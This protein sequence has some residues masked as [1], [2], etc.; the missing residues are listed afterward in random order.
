MV[1]LPS[2]TITLLF[3]DIEGSTRLLQELGDAYT[4]VLEE[5]H[6]R[7]REAFDAHAGAVVD[8]QGDGFFVA[9][10]RADEAVAAAAD[11]QRALA[12]LDGVRVRMGIH[13]GHPRRGGAGYVGLDVHRAA[14]ICAAAHGGQVLLSQTTHEL[15]PDA[16]A[17]DL[18][19]HRLRDLTN[20]QRLYQLQGEGLEASFAPLRTL[21]NRPT[22]L[23]VQ[24]TP[25]IGR[26]G[27]LAAITELMRR[28]D[29]RLVTLH[30]PGGCGKTRLALQA[31]AE[32]ID[33]FPEGVFFV[34]LEAV[35]DPGLVIPT[36]AQTLGVNDA[37]ASSL[38]EALAGFLADRRLLLVLDNFEHLLEAAPRLT[39]LLAR[40][41]VCMLV[42]SRAALR[43]TG[44][45]ELEVPPLPVPDARHADD[46]DAL[47]Q[48]E[49]SGA[50][51]RAR[52]GGQ[53]GLRRRRGERPSARRDLH[54][55]RR[56]AAR[57]RARG[58]PR[59]SCS[60]PR[61]C[62]PGSRTV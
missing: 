20:P 29:V 51:H 13:T 41:T 59:A 39:E 54:P 58:R 38:D 44:E 43:L 53:R 31:G 61:Q 5:H 19:E 12:G 30:G 11:A 21:E 8:V 3:T 18:G 22:N 2:G 42:T 48:Y 47:S 46:V 33:D 32:L 56:A 14:R 40:T 9:F 49:L 36:V 34:A 24:G 55:P 1:E 57:H 45:H 4:P 17:R 60:A 50:L 23:P 15:V 26:E 6:R 62:W 16:Q 35:E 25:L 10:E 28:P 27:E 52:P 37:G 7:L